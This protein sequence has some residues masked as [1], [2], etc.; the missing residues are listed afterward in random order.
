[1]GTRSYW[2]PQN[3]ARMSCP[4]PTLS[5]PSPRP[6]GARPGKAGTATGKG[7]GIVASALLFSYSPKCLEKLSDKSLWHLGR[8]RLVARKAPKRRFRPRCGLPQDSERGHLWN[9]QTVS[10]N[11]LINGKILRKRCILAMAGPPNGTKT[12]VSQTR[13]VLFG[14]YGGFA[15]Q[16]LEGVFSEVHLQDAA[17]P[18]SYAAS[19]GRA[20]LR[21]MGDA[22]RGSPFPS[23]L[24][25]KPMPSAKKTSICG[26]SKG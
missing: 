21:T 5:S 12:A 4:W 24:V 14:A 20:D 17:Y 9:Y 18:W 15:K 8:L 7:R 1:M 25:S 22:T 26:I 10:R 23:M 19:P 13:R 11:C 6:E 3:P 16:F 2:T